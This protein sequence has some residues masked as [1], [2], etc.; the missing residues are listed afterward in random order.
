MLIYATLGGD[1][2]AHRAEYLGLVHRLRR[3]I[4]WLHHLL[5]RTL[6]LMVLILYVLFSGNR[7][8]LTLD[9]RWEVI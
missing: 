4:P 6:A 9:F 3:A 7:M 8:A 1:D 5:T 2:R